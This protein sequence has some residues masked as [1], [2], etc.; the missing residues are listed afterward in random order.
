MSSDEAQSEFALLK[1]DIVSNYL[2]ASFSFQQFADYVLHNVLIMVASSLKRRN[3]L[4]YQWSCQL[5]LCHVNMGLAH[6]TGLRLIQKF[7]E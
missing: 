5:P 4:K 6:K 1:Q 3:S 2:Y 7:I